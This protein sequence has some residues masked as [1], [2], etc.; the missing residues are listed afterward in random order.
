MASQPQVSKTSS[1][2]GSFLQQAIAGA[3]SKL[4]IILAD[5]NDIASKNAS[6]EGGTTMTSKISAAEANAG[7][8]GS[9]S[10]YRSWLRED[11]SVRIAAKGNSSS[12][13]PV[14]SLGRPSRTA[15]LVTGDTITGLESPRR[16]MDKK[17]TEGVGGGQASL[18]GKRVSSRRASVCSMGGTTVHLD[19]PPTPEK[20]VVRS[21]VEYESIIA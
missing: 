11:L 14:A 12:D 2:W 7:N 9:P 6:S 5:S 15:S 16:T 1:R 20:G 10:L 17:A 18:D 19:L 21:L 8:D 4:D 3:E 13:S